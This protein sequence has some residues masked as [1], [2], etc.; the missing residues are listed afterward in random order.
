MSAEAVVEDAKELTGGWGWFLA[1]G[2]AWVLFAF[3]VLS[4]NMA[5]VWAIAV[6]FGIGF[7]VGGIME[8]AVAAVS[9]GWKWLYI[10]IGIVSI[11][12]GTIALIWPG[13]TFL[14][15]AA[16]IGWLLLFYGI[17]D[18][19]VSIGTRDA[20]DMWW[21][22]L[23]AGIA[24]VLLGLWAISPDNQTVSTWRGTVLL[25]F[26]VGI[27]ALMRGISDIID[28]FRL[29]SAHKRVEKLAA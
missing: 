2:I 22:Q 5:T 26:W 29:R 11:I 6:F 25:V 15:L 27:A 7:I 28:G 10:L 12:A 21:L 17:I 16:I 14:V 19:V 23:I 1:A 4:F 20:Y 24:M 18:I 13:E 3:V 9:P 8:L